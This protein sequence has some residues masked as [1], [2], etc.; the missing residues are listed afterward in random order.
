MGK[1][2][3]RCIGAIVA[4]GAY[5][6]SLDHD[7]LFFNNDV[8]NYIYNVAENGKFDIITF[9]SIYTTSYSNKISKMFDNPFSHHPNNLTLFQPQLSKYPL[10]KRKI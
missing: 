5:I 9:K 4:K 10:T 6:F 8:F 2:Y 1:L 3:S 7:D